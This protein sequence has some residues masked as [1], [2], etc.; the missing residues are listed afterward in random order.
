MLKIIGDIGFVAAAAGLALFAVMFLVS[1]RWWTDLLGRS[2]AAV[3]AVV[4]AIVILATIVLLGLP[5]PAVAWWRAI[6]YPALAVAV[7][8]GT[9][10]FIWAQYIAP[11][12]S[13]KRSRK[14]DRL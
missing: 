1:V 11:V 6:L 12:R 9:I 5:L 7:W 10:G 13:R 8:S 3:M 2:I 4:A 14:G